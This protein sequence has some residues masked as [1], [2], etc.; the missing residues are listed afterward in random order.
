V[1]RLEL[2]RAL[3]KLDDILKRNESVL[4][5]VED[6]GNAIVL[7]I[8]WDDSELNE[9]R[10]HQRRVCQKLLHEIYCCFHLLWTLS[11]GNLGLCPTLKQ[12]ALSDPFL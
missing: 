7:V 12:C 4:Q 6:V 8:D 1:L 2:T 11:E 10:P 9:Q 5:L 3:Q